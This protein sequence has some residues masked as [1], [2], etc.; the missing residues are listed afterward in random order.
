MAHP[1]EDY[2]LIGDCETAALVAR[3]GSIDW[4][5]WP[6]FDGGACFAALLGNPEHGHWQIAPADPG[7]RITRRYRDETLILET[8]F[9]TDDGVVTL[10]DFM[11]PRGSASHLVRMVTGQR[12]RVAMSCELVLR[13]DYGSLVPWVTRRDDG[14]LRAVAG[15]DMVLLRTPVVVRGQD[16]KTVGKFIVTEGETVPFVLSYGLSYRQPPGAIDPNAAL[17]ETETF[18]RKWSGSSKAAGKCS[19][20]VN[21]SL[22]TLKALTYRPTGGIVAAPTT[23]LPEQLG[24]TRNWDYRYCWLRDATFT[25]LSLMNGGFYDAARDWR[26][27]LLRAIAG[28]PQQAQIMY[29]I[30]GARRLT[31]VELPWLPGYEGAKPVRIGNAASNQLQLDVYGEVLDALYQA[32]RGG[33]GSLDAALDL[34]CAILDHLAE[35]WREPDD[36]IWEV[37]GGRQHFT[38]SKVM[39]WVAFDR[40]VKLSEE[41]GLDGPVDRWKTLRQEI[42]DDVCSKGFNS[43]IGAFTQHYGSDTLDASV[44]LM[45]LVGF[46]PASDPRVRG[47]VEAI[48]RNLMVDG[49]VMRYNTQSGKDGLPPGEGAFLACSFWFVDNLVLLGRLSEAEQM[50]ERLCALCNDV[51]LLS[52]EYDPHAKRLVGNFPQAFSHIALVNSAHNLFLAQNPLKQRA[53]HQPKP[54]SDDKAEA[55]PAAATKAVKDAG[56]G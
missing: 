10:V 56:A 1:I 20:L 4:L 25:L 2:A 43:S 36:G 51:G 55:S 44:L 33:L 6:R 19:A 39:A 28:S 14:A 27:W 31:E 16:F 46:L 3:D 45:P 13:F 47:T 53:E 21:R 17:R 48:E 54:E 52:E 15:P 8:E 5:C 37:R 26:E 18:W 38:Y 32:R 40:A 12:G 30:D 29:G 35:I 42:H 11:P 34:E 50:F 49:F 22:I 41:F 9:T 7:A 24:G 23:S